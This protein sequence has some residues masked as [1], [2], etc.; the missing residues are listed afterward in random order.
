M[1]LFALGSKWK[2]FS[3]YS[4]FCWVVPVLVML[5]ALV[6]EFSGLDTNFR[7][8]YGQHNCW[9]S[10][11]DSLL[12]FVVAPLCVVMAVNVVLFSWSAYLIYST[13]FKIENKSTSRADFRLFL[14]LALIMGLTWL[15]GLIAGVVNLTGIVYTSYGILQNLFHLKA[16]VLFYAVIEMACNVQRYITKCE[17]HSYTRLLRKFLGFH[18]H[19]FFVY[20]LF[21]STFKQVERCPIS[22]YQGDT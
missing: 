20:F 17:I 14:K 21:N 9:F 16:V 13:K 7:P 18:L 22:D 12:V 4:V 19:S 2:R 10:N 1:H 3:V 11:S 6:V 8:G 15:T 5:P